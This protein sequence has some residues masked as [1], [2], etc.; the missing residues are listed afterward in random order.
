M[1]VEKRTLKEWLKL[2]IQPFKKNLT[3]TQY[4]RLYIK[5]FGD[6]FNVMHK[7]YMDNVSGVNDG[8]LKE[9]SIQATIDMMSNI[10]L[11]NC[12]SLLYFER[13]GKTITVDATGSQQTVHFKVENAYFETYK[14]SIVSHI[15]GDNIHPEFQINAFDFDFTVDKFYK[16]CTDK[17]QEI[18][19]MNK[20]NLT[21]LNYY[22]FKKFYY[23][24]V[25]VKG[26]TA[27]NLTVG[28]E[29]EPYLIHYGY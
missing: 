5:I 3:Q 19:D 1:N 15:L 14:R 23:N 21:H 26:L 24:D 22:Y 28:I 2:D 20:N 4:D 10:M 6:I 25:A 29:V 27:R 16:K 17:F 12:D 7:L 13:L 9:A 8:L 18:F 11:E